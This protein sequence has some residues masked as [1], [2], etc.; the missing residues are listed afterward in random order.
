MPPTRQK[1]IGISVGRSLSILTWKA[2][3]S[4]MTTDIQSQTSLKASL[5]MT[6]M[7]STNSPKESKVMQRSREDACLKQRLHSQRRQQ[8]RWDRVWSVSLKHHTWQVY[9]RQ[10]RQW[11]WKT[12]LESR[13]QK[14]HAKVVPCMTSKHPLAVKVLQLVKEE[15]GRSHSHVK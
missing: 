14:V 8:N 11:L 15:A 4:S 7:L 13:T 5:P 2:L 3:T 6:Q 1:A 10:I 12:K 9:H